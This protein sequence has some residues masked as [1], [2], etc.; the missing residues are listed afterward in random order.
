M[1]PE[2]LE[3]GEAVDARHDQVEEDE[4]GV[5]AAVAE[6][7]DGA[8]A[9]FGGSAAKAVALG[10]CHEERTNAVIILDDEDRA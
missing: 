4:V 8:I 2:V 3:H 9:I 5:A 10:Y 7:F 1:S 6:R